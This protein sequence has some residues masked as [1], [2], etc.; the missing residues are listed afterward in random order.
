M[1]VTTRNAL[2]ARDGSDGSDASSTAGKAVRAAAAQQ[3]VMTDQQ[4]LQNYVETGSQD[5]FAQLVSR[6]VDL[7][8][9]A[10]LRQVRNSHL[11]EDVTQAVFILLAKKAAGLKRE[12]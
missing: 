8:Y 4:L 2:G 1:T 3:R 5:A 10:A 9:G 7:V 11:A 12:I 6:H